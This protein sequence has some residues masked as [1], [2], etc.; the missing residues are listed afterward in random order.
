MNTSQRLV[1][2]VGVLA[3][4]AMCA[5]PP[6]SGGYYGLDYNWLWG[7]GSIDT[8]RLGL[9]FLLVAGVTGLL[10]Y[11][12]RPAVIQALA[13]GK[14]LAIQAVAKRKKLLI[15]L[16]VVIVTV[17]T[18]GTVGQVWGEDL[19]WWWYRLPPEQVSKISVEE[20]L[21]DARWAR[22]AISLAHQQQRLVV[23][24][25]SGEALQ[26]IS[27]R[28]YYPGVPAPATPPPPPGFVL[29]TSPHG[30]AHSTYDHLPCFVSAGGQTEVTIWI[31]HEYTPP[32]RVEV[33]EAWRR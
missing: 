20:R 28:I 14:K 15:V 3:L 29:D 10:A 25:G 22:E 21:P 7:H 11:G 1:V 33:V 4:L 24:N 8:A 6:H 9:Q 12:L 31:E 13:K 23:T 18:I 32:L 16:V 5:Y 17:G 19:Y 26:A 2:A 27:I 30:L